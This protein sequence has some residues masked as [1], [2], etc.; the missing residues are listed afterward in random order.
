MRTRPSLY[1]SD[2]ARDREEAHAGRARI[3]RSTYQPDGTDARPSL[4]D[5]RTNFTTF[6]EGHLSEAIYFGLLHAL[7]SCATYPEV[8]RE[9]ERSLRVFLV[10]ILPVSTVYYH[11][12][13]PM[14]RALD[15]IQHLVTV[16]ASVSSK[17]FDDWQ[18]FAN[19]A[20][21]RHILL[22]S[23]ER[24]EITGFRACD[25]TECGEILEKSR[26]KR[27]GKCNSMYYCSAECQYLDWKQG[28]HKE[29][30]SQSAILDLSGHMSTRERSFMRILVHR[31]YKAARVATIYPAQV[32][33][34]HRYP[35]EAYL[36]S[37]DYSTGHVQIDV[38]PLSQC[39]AASA[40]ARLAGQAWTEELSRAAKSNG[41]TEI[42]VMVVVSHGSLRSFVVPL[43]TNSSKMHE[44]LRTLASEIPPGSDTA[45]MLPQLTERIQTLVDEEEPDVVRIHS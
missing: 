43:R 26:F 13:F 17:Y 16:P 45:E 2:S 10:N 6:A 9:I 14:K 11:H 38:Q 18:K 34:M 35:N 28:G 33:C 39:P 19:L 37:F 25:N 41:K 40:I 36:T 44:A 20:Y 22:E 12:L 27:C 8:A 15:E 4:H 23:F 5:P 29:V 7:V 32:L 24:R 3:W 1:R 30:C 42:H 21:E 31:H